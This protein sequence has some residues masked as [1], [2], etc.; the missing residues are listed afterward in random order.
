MREGFKGSLQQQDFL[1]TFDA[2]KL[3]LCFQ[4]AGGG[5]AQRLISFAPTFYVSRHPLDRGQARFDRVGG[6]EFAPQHCSYTQAMHRQRFFQP[7]LQAGAAL[8][9]IRS[10]CRKIFCKASLASA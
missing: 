2:P 10:N 4:K 8:G 3:L 7:F 5:P 1:I 9:L 6:G